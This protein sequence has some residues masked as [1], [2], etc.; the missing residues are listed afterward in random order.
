[1]LLLLVAVA[2][3]AQVT[4]SNTVATPINSGSYYNT[5]TLEN[6]SSGGTAYCDRAATSSAVTSGTAG[7]VLFTQGSNYISNNESSTWYCV[8]STPSMTIGYTQK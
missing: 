5:L 4:I 2:W 6:L 1:M 7:I 3:G 8:G